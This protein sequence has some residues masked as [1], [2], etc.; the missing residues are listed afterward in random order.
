MARSC[1]FFDGL[2]TEPP[3]DFFAGDFLAGD[4][5]AGDFFAGDFFA[6]DFFAGDFF[7]GD[8]FADDFDVRFFFVFVA[9][10]AATGRTL[11]KHPSVA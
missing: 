4:F 7:A 3:D 6:G 10:R 11:A 2:A 9:R 1:T 8:F 5:F